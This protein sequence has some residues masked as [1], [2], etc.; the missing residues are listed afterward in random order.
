MLH[1]NGICISYDRVLQISAQLG[2]AVVAKYVE[3]GVVCPPALRKGLFTTSAVDNINH[4]QTAT[5]ATTSFQGTSVSVFQHPSAENLGEVREPYI[6]TEG[7]V[8]TV[9]GG[10]HI[11]MATFRSIGSLLESGWT[12]ALSEAGVASS[13]TADSFLTV[14]SVTRTRQAHQRTAVSLYR[15]MKKAYN[16][17]CSEALQNGQDTIGLEDWQEKRKRESPQFQF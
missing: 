6:I 9:L 1:D 16:D 14:S 10:L 12:S 8:R 15:L 5:T 3:D 7:K 2:D 13:G 4:N 17:H 11:Q